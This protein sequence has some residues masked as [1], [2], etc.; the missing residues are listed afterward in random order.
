MGEGSPQYWHK[1]DQIRHR[2]CD[3]HEL[4]RQAERPADHGVVDAIG[5]EAEGDG[6]HVVEEASA[7]V[8]LWVNVRRATHRVVVQIADHVCSFKV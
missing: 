8:D 7:S 6:E 2:T 1:V 3:V 5:S 4:T